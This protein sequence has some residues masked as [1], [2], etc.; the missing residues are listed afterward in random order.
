MLRILTAFKP[1]S[2][3]GIFTTIFLLIF[4]ISLA[5]LSMPSQFIE[6][7]SPLIGPS[8]IDVISFITS[9]KSRPSLAISDGFVVTP[10]ITPKSFAFFISSIFAVSTKIFIP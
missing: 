3:I 6:I 9:L 5:S 7:T 8:T 1:S 10:H 4:A 2:H